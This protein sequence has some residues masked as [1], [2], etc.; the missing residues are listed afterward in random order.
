MQVIFMLYN[1]LGKL[2]HDK[3]FDSKK[4]MIDFQFIHDFFKF[5]FIATFLTLKPVNILYLHRYTI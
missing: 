1:L 2:Y 3:C 5:N 4:L